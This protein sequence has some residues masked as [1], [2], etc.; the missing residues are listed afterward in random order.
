MEKI[1]FAAY[2]FLILALFPIWIFV[3]FLRYPKSFASHFRQGLSQRLG[4]V[5]ADIRAKVRGA[6]WIHAASLGECRA[7]VPFVRALKKSHPGVPI[8][9]TSTTLNGVAEAQNLGL[10]DAA[11]FAPVDFPWS[12]RRFLDAVEPRLLLLLESELWPNWLASAQKRGIPIGVLNGRMSGRS[13]RRYGSLPALSRI[14]MG[15]ISFAAVREQKDADHY[16]TA[17]LQKDKIKV[18]G[19]LKYDLAPWD[20]NGG[21]KPP[22]QGA[23][24]AGKVWT[25]GSVREGEERQIL[26]VFK[27]LKKDFPEL[28]LILAPRHLEN[29]QEIKALI[30]SM[31]LRFSSR[32]ENPSPSSDVELWDTFGDLWRAY[33]QSDF[34]FV[35]GSLVDKGGQN[36]IEPA[37]FA[38]PVLF[39]RSMHNFE[40][41]ARI[42]MEQGAAAQVVDAGELEQK[43]RRLLQNPEEAQKMGE[44]ARRA[45]ENFAGSATQKTLQMVEPYLK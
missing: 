16:Q 17:G 19:N 2:S 7:A 13:A 8:L 43:M 1:L 33:E 14:L 15:K 37:W 31:D 6:V 21:A 10:G 42:L 44:H 20:L 12:V 30:K 39:G 3:V 41:P 9:F 28:K 22:L 27:K 5:E 4:G 32:S 25:A 38:K 34:V 29:L 35:G 24:H 23:A 40:E 36:P 11:V 18:T 26:E 45:M